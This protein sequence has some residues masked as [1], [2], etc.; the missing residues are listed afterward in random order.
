MNTSRERVDNCIKLGPVKDRSDIP[1]MPM[2]VQYPG[3]CANIT[4]KEMVDKPKKWLEAVKHTFDTYG[5]PDLATVVPLG[6]VIFS[7]G[8]EY[9]RPGYELGDNDQFQLLEKQHLEPEDY[10]KILKDGWAGWF[11]EYMKS[12]QKPLMKSNF[13]L[14]LRWIQLGIHCGN[15]VK[16]LRNLGVEPIAGT[17]TMPLFDRL[18][19]IR[20]FEPFV[21]DLYDEPGL[22]HDILNQESPKETAAAI[23]NAKMVK[24]D[25]IQAYPMR[26]D[27]NSISP[28]LF[29]E[30]AFPHLKHMVEEFHKAGYTTVMHADSN[31]NPILDRFL[32]LPK[33]SILFEF[34]GVTDIR[35]AYEVIGGHHSMRGDVPASMLAFGTPDE[36]SEYCEGLITDLGMKGGFVLSSGCEIPMNIKPENLTA[37][38]DSILQAR[39]KG[40]KA[41][42]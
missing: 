25:R 20:S 3:V 37:F 16:F 4:Q 19:L 14:T 38:M 33:G 5:Y 13:K 7:E 23:G 34:D 30:F 6:D 26:V 36:V 10:K 27:S 8:L 15:S 1:I 42:A 41:A 29:D 21:F 22:I 39:K 35:K 2:Y 18:S 32:Q 40:A 17:A 12:I 31:W 9:M 11:N 24:C 28:D